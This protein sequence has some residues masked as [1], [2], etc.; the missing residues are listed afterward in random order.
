M[1]T[2]RH[3]WIRKIIA[4]HCSCTVRAYSRSQVNS[5]SHE[6]FRSHAHTA[7]LV[8]LLQNSLLPQASLPQTKLASFPS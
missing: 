7:K 3:T 5:H 1:G 8:Q 6:H 4:F 2:V